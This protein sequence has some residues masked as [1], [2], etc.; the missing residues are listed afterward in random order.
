MIPGKAGGAGIG[1]LNKAKTNPTR[2]PVNN[3]SM[4]SFIVLCRP[5][6]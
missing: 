6:L 2:K 1:N 5:S 4:M 3:D